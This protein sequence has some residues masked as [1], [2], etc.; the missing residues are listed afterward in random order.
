MGV[1]DVFFMAWGCFQVEEEERLWT[2]VIDA[3][4]SVDAEW[5]PDILARALGN[6]G[7]ARSRQVQYCTVLF[8]VREFLSEISSSNLKIADFR[9]AKRRFD[10]IQKIIDFYCRFFSTSLL[11]V[12][13]SKF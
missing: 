5:V 8:C 13:E 10:W 12:D 9:V 4:G 6:R 11:T 1:A 7:N 3:Y 2:E